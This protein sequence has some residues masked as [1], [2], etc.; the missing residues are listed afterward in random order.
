MFR[1]VRTWVRYRPRGKAVVKL[2]R[3]KKEATSNQ[4]AG[5]VVFDMVGFYAL[6]MVKRARKAKP[7]GH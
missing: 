7:Y 5:E 6:G 1:K 3:T 2:Y 4:R